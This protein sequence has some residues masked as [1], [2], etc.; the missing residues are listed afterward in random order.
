VLW[1][2]E[3]VQD[4]VGVPVFGALCFVEA[5]WPLIGGSFTVRGVE[6]L[7]PKKIASRVSSATGS[8]DVERTWA[9]LLQAFPP[10]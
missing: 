5:D 1:Q 9:A 3:K 8:I 7:W 10:A 2:V 4:A 6:A